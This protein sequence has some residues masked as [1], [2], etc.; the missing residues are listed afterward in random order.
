MYCSIGSRSRIGP[1]LLS[2]AAG[3]SFWAALVVVARAPNVCYAS[4]TFSLGFGGR[5]QRGATR[6]EARGGVGVLRLG[7]DVVI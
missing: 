5:V 6:L 3:V 4:R 1:R 2:R 7:V